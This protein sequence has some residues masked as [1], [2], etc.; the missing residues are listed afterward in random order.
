MLKYF[1]LASKMK[2]EIIEVKYQ[3]HSQLCEWNFPGLN[4][5]KDIKRSLKFHDT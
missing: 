2:I 4:Y 3:V 1:C 5:L